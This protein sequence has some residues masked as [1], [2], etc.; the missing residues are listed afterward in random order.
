M[1]A[2]L[3]RSVFT[4]AM[5]RSLRVGFVTPHNPHDRK[6]FSGTVHHAVRALSAVRGLEVKVL[7]GHRPLPWHHRLSRR[8]TAQ[9]PVSLCWSDFVGVDVVVGLVA[10]R[11]LLE[12]SALTQAPLVHV[13]DATPSFL[14]EVY[15]FTIPRAADAEE[16][17]VLAAARRIVYSSD[18]MAERAVSEFGRAFRDRVGAI[19][20]GT[21]CDDLPETLP[22]KPDLSPVRLLWVGSQWVRKGGEIALSAARTLHAS[23]M[24]VH[25]TLVGD[26][27][28]TVRS[29]PGIEVAGY[30]DKSRPKHA[31][32]LRELYAGAHVFVLPTRADCTPM[33]LAE[34]GAHGTP[35][36]V[37]DT[38][39]VGSLVIEGVN[40]RLLAPGASPA[41]WATAIRMMTRNRARHAALCRASFEHARTRLT[42]D[43]W[44]QRMAVFLRTEFVAAEAR[45]AVAAA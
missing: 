2:P 6:A 11:L 5:D 43:A 12:A 42:W 15:G 40:G 29:G 22:E 31:A 1:S 16:A 37:T 19:T 35:V 28:D 41:D 9:Q 21:N 20:F 30:L 24:D 10:T 45:R 23:G 14:R 18:Y 34:A 8:F 7:G 44:A 13:T 3:P 32:R 27:P 26:V 25:L 38:G 17:R 36:L 33:V 4:A 39:G